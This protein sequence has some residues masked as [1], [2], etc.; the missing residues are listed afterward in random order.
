MIAADFEVAPPPLHASRNAPIT[1]RAPR[2]FDLVGLHWSS[3]GK[4]PTVRLRARRDGGR[5]SA[6]FHLAPGDGGPRASDPLW[7]GG[8][9]VVQYR[10]SHPVRGL[11]VH[12]VRTSGAAPAPR[13]VHAASSSPSRPT[14]YRRSAWGAGQCK[15][16]VKPEIGQVS[17]A[18]I[19]HTVTSNSYSPDDVPGMILAIC[20]YH[21]NSNGWND[22]GY[23]FLVDRFGR[24]WEG[25]AG[26]ISRAVVGAHTL[27]FNSQSTG[28][29]N[30]GTFTSVNQTDDA[31]RAMA[32]LIRWKLPLHGTP[33]AGKATLVS[34]GG[35]GNRWSYGKRVKFHRISGH[36]DADSTSCPGDALYAQLPALRKRVGSVEPQPAGPPPAVTM[37]EPAHQ[38]E[39]GRLLSVKGSIDPFKPYVTIAIDKRTPDRWRSYRRIP[40]GVADGGTF[41]KKLR[42]REHGH[43]RV[44]ARFSGDGENGPARSAIYRVRVTAP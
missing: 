40:I 10:L 20:R 5:W 23:N 41:D 38:M 8:A 15:P 1:V 2:R 30:L 7:T 4:T 14:I 34:G 17:V 27:G 9:D 18:F 25:R 28:I 16:R 6:W 22:I 31:L 44:F 12:F 33:T 13:T 24:L 42:L 11:R 32:R 39:A 26:G 19:H 3:G 37:D 21:R 43:Y 35:P 29:S 36:R